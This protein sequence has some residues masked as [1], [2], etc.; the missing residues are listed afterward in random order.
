MPQRGKK[1][2]AP[3]GLYT[4]REAINRL[5]MPPATFHNYVKEGKLK[6]IMPLGRS[7]GYYEKAYIDRMAE[8][9]ELLAIQYASD[10]SIFSKA[11]KED[12]QGIYDVMV[13]LW[14]TLNVTP[15]ETRISWMSVNPDMDYVVKKEGIVVGYVTIKPYKNGIMDKIISGEMLAKDVNPTDILPFTPGIPLEC[16]VG[17][18]VRA[19]VY[20]P[21]KY[22]MRL[23]A[24]AI[25]VLK[26]LAKKGVIISK[27][28]ANSETPD[29]IKLCHE[30]GFKDITLASNKTPRRFLLDFTTSEEPLV[31]EYQKI[32]EQV[33]EKDNISLQG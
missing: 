16:L 3:E 29:G 15:V 5:H 13:S 14:G 2:I 26:D 10:S 9:K 27:L 28:Y 33:K 1:S 19:G 24:G 7:E 25:K 32:L 30:L 22:G 18:A 6:K 23:I 8:A 17:T 4:A 20:Q 31:Q 21:E 11:T 12:M